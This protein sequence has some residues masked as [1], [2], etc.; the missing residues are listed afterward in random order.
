MT[1]QADDANLLNELAARQ[2]K[3]KR[4]A[5]AV[6]VLRRAIE[7]EPDFPGAHNNLGNA[8]VHLKRFDDMIQSDFR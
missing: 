3:A 1:Q 2:I 5:E 6:G 4:A 8:Y 7:I